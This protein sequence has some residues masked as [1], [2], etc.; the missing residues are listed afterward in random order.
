MS[1]GNFWQTLF[2]IQPKRAQ[3]THSYKIYYMELKKFVC[4]WQQTEPRRK[5]SSIWK[6]KGSDDL[7][8]LCEQLFGMKSLYLPLFL[9]CFGVLLDPVKNQWVE[10]L[11]IFVYSWMYKGT[12][13]SCWERMKAFLPFDLWQTN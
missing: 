12:L 1:L 13:E 3:W 7:V 10:I 8:G 4:Q 6:E 5:L 2:T 11:I 9:G